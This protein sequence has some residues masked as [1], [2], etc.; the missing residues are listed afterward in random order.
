MNIALIGYGKMGKEVETVLSER[1]HTVSIRVDKG[2]P[3]LPGDLKDTDIAIEF[4][5]P[6]AAADNILQCFE[7][8]C[9]VVV[10]TTGWYNRLPEI[11]TEALNRSQS[12]LYATNF[13]IGV[14]IL[15][16]LNRELARI[17]K[18]FP[19]YEPGMIEIHHTAKL[20]KPS[21]TAISLAEGIIEELSRKTKWVNDLSSSPEELSI[22]SQ[23][24]GDIP[25]THMITYSGTEDNLS[26]IH[27]AKGRKGF[28]AGAVMAAEWLFGKKGVYTI[29]DF[30]KF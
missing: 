18:N 26:L 20:D 15:F 3:F 1:G 22:I 13:S 27:E 2:R 10:G 12:I 14:N 28:A 19:G 6:S 4:S 7:A 11:R 16:H 9:P 30:L 8:G 21:G 24:E 23:R 25:G 17:M 29:H 5:T